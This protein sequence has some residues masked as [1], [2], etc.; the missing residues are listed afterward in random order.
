VALVIQHAKFM[1]CI[2]LSFVACLAVSYFPPYLINGTIFGKMLMNIEFVFWFRLQLLPE[3][4][5]IL[6]RTEHIIIKNVPRSSCNIPI[7][8]VK[9]D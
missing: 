1:H 9:F 8:V 3:I 7:I 4:F 6:R 2:L 5:F